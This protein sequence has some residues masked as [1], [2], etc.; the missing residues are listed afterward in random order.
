MHLEPISTSGLAD[1]PDLAASTRRRARTGDLLRL[2]RGLYVDGDDWA[3]AAEHE[4]HRLFLQS[5]VPKLADGLVVSHRSAVALHG[6][7]WIGSFGERVVV[8]DPE[9]DRGQ[10][11]RSVERIGSAGRRPSTVSVDGLPVTDLVGTAVDVA[12]REHPW[13]AI[14]VLDSVLRRGVSRSELLAEAEGRRARNHRRARDLLEHAN[15]DAESPGE[16]ITRWGAH[17]LGAPMPVLQH[18]FR[19][20]GVLVDRVDLW[21]PA[22]R[23]VVEFDGRSKY[24]DPGLRNGRTAAEVLFDEKRREDR[25]RRRPDVHG[26]AR[27]TWA[28]AMPGGQLPRRLSDAGVPL[29]EGW[30]AAWRAAAHR[31]L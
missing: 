10:V 31:A 11:K 24:V 7:P 8:T 2:H 23:V 17:V 6:L 16:S 13:R 1:R 30:A 15:A 14:V 22:Q 27:V 19:H 3:A 28:D 12:L 18:S 4:R 26:F 9:R 21:F 29:G 5:V 25:I 20:D